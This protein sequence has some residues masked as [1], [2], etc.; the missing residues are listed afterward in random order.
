[1]VTNPL[2]KPWIYFDEIWHTN[3]FSQVVSLDFMTN[4]SV[5]LFDSP[6][7]IELLNPVCS[8]RLFIFNLSR[9]STVDK[10]N[11]LRLELYDVK[12]SL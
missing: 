9:I 6:D 4:S 7:D 1:M 11:M 2:L 5:F 12:F 3:R 10:V 8:I